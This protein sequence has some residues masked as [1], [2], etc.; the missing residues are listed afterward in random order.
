MSVVV[1]AG[2]RYRARLTNDAWVGFVVVRWLWQ[3]AIHSVLANLPCAKH[4]R[5]D[6]G[7]EGP[8][9]GVLQDEVL[10]GHL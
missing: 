7:G 3:R 6:A 8:L 4:R 5:L 2:A 1:A 9:D 10:V